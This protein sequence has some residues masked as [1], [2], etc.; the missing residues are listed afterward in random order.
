MSSE[1]ESVRALI[2]DARYTEAQAA[3]QAWSERER[4][5]AD[6]WFYLGLSAFF[7]EQ[8]EPA[9]AALSR[10][11]ELDAGHLSPAVRARARYPDLR[12]ARE[13]AQDTFGA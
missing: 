2:Q 9:I 1:K 7:L 8:D 11:L 5:S 6:A 3:A 13:T 4:G 12:A 10:A